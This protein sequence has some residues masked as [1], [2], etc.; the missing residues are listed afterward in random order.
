MVYQLHATVNIVKIVHLMSKF[1]K[2]VYY[3]I[4][5]KNVARFIYIRYVIICWRLSIRCTHNKLSMQ[6]EQHHHLG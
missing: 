2:I 6:N 4:F 3:L 1:A 5:C